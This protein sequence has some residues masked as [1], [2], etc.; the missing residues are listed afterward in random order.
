[1]ILV[2]D[3]RPG[4]KAQT[5]C[6]GCVRTVSLGAGISAD[7]YIRDEIFATLNLLPRRE[8]QVVTAD[9]ELRRRVLEIRPIVRGV[10]NPVTFWRRYLPRLSGRKLPKQ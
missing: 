5:R 2:F 3:G 8:V 10:I 1:M 4:E 6:Q 7:D 9:R